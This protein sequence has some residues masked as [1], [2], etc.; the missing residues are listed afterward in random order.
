ME[1][2][3]FFIHENFWLAI[4]S[5]RHASYSR[6][7]VELCRSA[8]PSTPLFSCSLL[9]TLYLPISILNLVIHFSDASD[10]NR[11]KSTEISLNDYPQLSSDFEVLKFILQNIAENIK[12]IISN[13]LDILTANLPEEKRSLVCFDNILKVDKLELMSFIIIMYLFIIEYKL[14]FFVM[15]Q[16]QVLNIKSGSELEL[17]KQQFSPF[18]RC[19]T[20]NNKITS[21]PSKR[22]TFPCITHSKHGRTITACKRTSSGSKLRQ[23]TT[24]TGLKRPASTPGRR[25]GI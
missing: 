21:P 8:Q 2:S 20:C 23:K 10:T 24:I 13:K 25:R 14:I 19:S 5:I 15:L 6:F 12:Y 16:K 3:R 11:K 7:S 22:L 17:L 1:S 4:C 18:I 9:I